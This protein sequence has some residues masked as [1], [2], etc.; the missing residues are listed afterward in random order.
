MREAFEDAVSKGNP[1]AKAG[2]VPLTA[3]YGSEK[4]SH[5]LPDESRGPD[6]PLSA[7]LDSGL[8]RSDGRPEY[9]TEFVKGRTS[10]R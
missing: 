10:E 6:I 3:S 5:I 2:L 4:G 7:G 8:R 9:V 1:R